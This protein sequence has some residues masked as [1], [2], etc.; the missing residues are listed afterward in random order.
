MTGSYISISWHMTAIG[1]AWFAPSG[2][3]G[4]LCIN[5]GPRLYD[6][7]SLDIFMDCPVNARL[8][9][10][11]INGDLADVLERAYDICDSIGN[12]VEGASPLVLDAVQLAG[13]IKALLEGGD[14]T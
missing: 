10:A 13:E 11:A 1:R 6:Y 12:D 2:T 8:A 9:A 4:R 7:P 5:Q 14:T 3:G